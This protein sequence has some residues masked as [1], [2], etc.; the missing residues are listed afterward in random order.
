MSSSLPSPPE[1]AVEIAIPGD[2]MFPPG[3]VPEGMN[4]IA[5]VTLAPDG[6]TERLRLRPRLAGFERRQSQP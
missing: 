3:A 4:F 5:D 6:S 2:A 1:P